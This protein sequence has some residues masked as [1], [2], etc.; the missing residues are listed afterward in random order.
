MKTRFTWFLFGFFLLL[1]FASSDGAEPDEITGQVLD[2]AGKP[3]AG[4]KVSPSWISEEGR[5]TT[6][7][8]TRTDAEGRFAYKLRYASGRLMAF[9]ATQEH[10]A[11]V[12]V[13]EETARQPLTLKL[14]PTIR[15][16][17][18][19]TNNELGYE[20]EK[21]YVTFT[22]AWTRMGVAAHRGKPSF[23]L[24][25]PAGEYKMTIGGVDCKRTAQSITLAED[26]PVLDLG[27]VN[28]KATIIAKHY[29]KAPPAW[30]VSDAR[31]VDAK[32]TLSDFKGKWVL[33]EFWGFW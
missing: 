25:L 14:R 3:V 8:G 4:I 10:G 1:G 15:V 5:W 29:G 9:D 7:T 33:L 21:V 19:Y 18:A 6:R 31:G 13:N 2:A 22:P 24:R 28:L 32:A 12:Q 11:V 20:I 16:R 23:D 17:G 26:K 30:N 27:T